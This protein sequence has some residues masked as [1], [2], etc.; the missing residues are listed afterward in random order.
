[1]IRFLVILL[2][3]GIGVM[4]AAIRAN[5]HADNNKHYAL[6]IHG[7]AGTIL[8]KNMTPERESLIRAKL[9]EALLAGQLVL[10]QGGEAVDA[11]AATINVMENSPLFNA[12]KGAVFNHEGHNEMDA[13]I[14]DGRDLNAGA[15]AGVTHVKNPINLAR[16]VMRNSKHV[17]LFG[18]GAEEFAKLQHIEL[19]EPEYFWT[20]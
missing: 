14:M 18:A 4:T 10:D 2:I 12:G 3:G 17:M 6:V 16:E 7:G 15:V 11:V 5:A 1:M 19:V 9:E 20:E 13:S 8:K